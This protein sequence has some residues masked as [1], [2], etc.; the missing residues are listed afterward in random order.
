MSE[1][2]VIQ[3]V[4][5]QPHVV[6]QWFIDSYGWAIITIG[7]L[8]SYIWHDYSKRVSNLE[9]DMGDVRSKVTCEKLMNKMELTCEKDNESLEKVLDNLHESI[10]GVHLR[11]DKL[12]EEKRPT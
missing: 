2:E 1:K 6:V 9:D 5:E 7:G 8:A 4:A 12:Y 11:L 10:K 3:K